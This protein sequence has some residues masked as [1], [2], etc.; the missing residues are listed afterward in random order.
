MEKAVVPYK[1]GCL[2]FPK[3]ILE[4]S[5]SNQ[6]VW[7]DMSQSDTQPPEANGSTSSQGKSK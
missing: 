4:L 3:L 7:M 6:S 1:V 5:F 2:K